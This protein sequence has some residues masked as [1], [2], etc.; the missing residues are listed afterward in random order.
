MERIELSIDPEL[1][2]RF[3]GQRAARIVMET[4]DGRREEY[5]QP[6]RKGDP[7]EP[8]SDVELG[9]KFV[10]LVAPVLGV[11]EAALLLQRLW[12]LD[13]LRSLDMLGARARTPAFATH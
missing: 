11:T 2:A 13:S 6:T 10:E 9:D 5:L 4:R 3:P 12:N 8:L 7:E 1:D